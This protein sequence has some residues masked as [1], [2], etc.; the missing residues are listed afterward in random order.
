MGSIR[1][2][3]GAACN[4]PKAPSHG[5]QDPGYLDGGNEH[6]DVILVSDDKPSQI[7]GSRPPLGTFDLLEIGGSSFAHGSGYSIGS[8][9][10]I[11]SSAMNVV[12]K[13]AATYK[14]MLQ[15]RHHAFSRSLVLQLTAALGL[16]AI[17][18][19]SQGGSRGHRHIEM[20]HTNTC[21]AALKSMKS[22]EPLPRKGSSRFGLW[23]LIR[24]VTTLNSPRVVSRDGIRD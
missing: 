13:I 2:N 16:T 19:L 11:A 24:V 8:R 14:A 10:P 17:V 20:F 23:M 21:L 3:E 22:G 15:P 7:A 5:Y 6:T 1:V 9:T 4:T 18:R 12:R